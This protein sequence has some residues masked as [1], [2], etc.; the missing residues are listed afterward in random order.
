VASV[1]YD[2]ANCQGEVQGIGE[3]QFRNTN[4]AFQIGLMY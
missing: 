3:M 4:L 2:W 1:K